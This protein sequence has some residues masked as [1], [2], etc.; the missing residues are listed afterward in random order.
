M[1]TSAWLEIS[2]SALQHNLAQ[3][4]ALAPESKVMAMVKADAYGHALSPCVDALHAADGFAV[5]RMDE[6]LRLRATGSNHRI[7]LLGTLL[8]ESDLRLCAEQKLDVIIHDTDTAQ[9]LTSL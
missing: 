6:A 8:S 4:R 9:R 7:L 3:V 2:R 5:A 1:N